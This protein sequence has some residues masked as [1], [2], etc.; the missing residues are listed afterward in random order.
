MWLSQ[1]VTKGE[2][3]GVHKRCWGSTR[4]DAR[5]H[6]VNQSVGYFDMLLV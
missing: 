1:V 6:A 3:D 4:S 2:V 5:S